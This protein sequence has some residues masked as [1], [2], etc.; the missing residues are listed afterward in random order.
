MY[1]DCLQCYIKNMDNVKAVFKGFKSFCPFLLHLRKGGNGGR[2][3]IFIYC[4]EIK[5]KRGHPYK[6]SG[7]GNFFVPINN[8]MKYE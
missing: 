2:A 6:S 3:I 7:R 5:L 1:N 8:S 4:Y